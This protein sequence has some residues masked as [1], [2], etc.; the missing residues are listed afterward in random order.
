MH[1]T[2]LAEG[3][4]CPSDMFLSHATTLDFQ[5]SAATLHSHGKFA[6][7]SPLDAS[8]ANQIAKFVFYFGYE[9]LSAHPSLRAASMLGR[10]GCSLVS[11]AESSSESN[12]STRSLSTRSAL[13]DTSTI[14]DKILSEH[15]TAPKTSIGEASPIAA[16]TTLDF[17]I[18]A[19]EGETSIDLSEKVSIDRTGKVLS[20]S[21]DAIAA[22]GYIAGVF[23]ANV[24]SIVLLDAGFGFL[25]LNCFLRSYEAATET[26]A[27]NKSLVEIKTHMADEPLKTLLTQH[28]TKK[29]N[30]NLCNAVCLA[31]YGA[32]FVVSYAAPYT[33]LALFL[34]FI[35]ADYGGKFAFKTI[36]G[37]RN[38]K[39]NFNDGP[40]SLE[41]AD[42]QVLR[43]LLFYLYREQAILNKFSNEKSDPHPRAVIKALIAH[44]KNRE[45]LWR[46][47]QACPP[48]AIHSIIVDPQTHIDDL[49]SALTLIGTTLGIDQ[50]EDLPPFAPDLLKALSTGENIDY[51]DP[52][53]V[54]R[55]QSFLQNS[56]S[57]GAN[58]LSDSRHCAQEVSDMQTP[59]N[60]ILNLLAFSGVPTTP[61]QLELAQLYDRAFDQLSI[62]R[63]QRA[64]CFNTIATY[65]Q[66]QLL[67][68]KSETEPGN[69]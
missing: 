25:T 63:Q 61:E 23:N 3:S 56:D 67:N 26:K 43:A 35:A 9:L 41:K 30:A 20:I 53:C 36:N 28:V 27:L 48:E 62:T 16:T 19:L 66:N 55:V 60:D 14:D 44:D 64:E 2:P 34:P 47:L 24:L 52:A 22:A 39:I 4:A 38:E 58:Q 37:T 59:H 33:A 18:S 68:M 29:R 11:I 49:F 7:V 54:K 5:D 31:G 21:G 6:E 65:F 13:S 46:A 42:P 32:A 50:P 12:S 8:E 69:A 1:P 57:N 40:I 51:K 15:V 10:A 45:A 17:D